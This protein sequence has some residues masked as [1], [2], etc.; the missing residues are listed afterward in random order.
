MKVV[1]TGSTGMVGKGVLLV[2][3]EDP[4]ISEIL[5]IN[6]S[7]LNMNHP[8]LKELL[9]P[10]FGK[11]DQYQSKLTNY[12]A[13]FFCMGISSVGISEEDYNAITYD[14]TTNFANIF[15]AA[16][17]NSTFI[18]VSGTGTDSSE[19]G[20]IMWARVKGKTEN[21]ILAMPF[22]AAY[23]F[24][25]GFIQPMRDISSK[26]KLYRAFYAIS[27]PLYPLLKS[28][29]PKAITNT[30]QMGWAMINLAA[31]GSD[32]KWFYNKDINEAA[33]NL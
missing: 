30:D 13:C 8:K 27:T 6:R 24:R 20:K 9:L 12:D 11:I 22:K 31:N 4:R 26:F 16:N 7:S 10:D 3:L 25:P 14:L 15:I 5:L 32:K 29:F 19:K 2:C 1:I 28:I 23:M 17:P 18:Y 33:D 21:A